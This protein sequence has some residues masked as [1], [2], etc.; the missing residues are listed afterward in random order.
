[1]DYTLFFLGLIFSS[2]ITSSG[3]HITFTSKPTAVVDNTYEWHRD[4]GDPPQFFLQKIK[5]D[6]PTGA[7]PPSTPVPVPQA[8]SSGGRSSIFFNRAG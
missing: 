5:V 3:L 8:G 2:I 6:D 1:M 4:P 7:T